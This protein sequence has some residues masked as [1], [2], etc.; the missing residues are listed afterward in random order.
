MSIPG[1]ITGELSVVVDLTQ[2]DALIATLTV[3]IEVLIEKY[4]ILIEDD[5]KHLVPVA[6]GALRDSIT[7]TLEALAGEVTAGNDTVDYAQY[8]EYG[9]A[10]AAAQPF[11][12][13][14]FERYAPSFLAELQAMIGGV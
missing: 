3:K 11:L 10:R 12:R 4:L 7:H 8:V 2:L 1:A 5:A 6:T 14:A 13:P 9:T